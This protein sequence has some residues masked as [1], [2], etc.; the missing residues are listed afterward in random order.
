MY[1]NRERQKWICLL[2]PHKLDATILISDWEFN[3]SS[4][5]NIYVCLQ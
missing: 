2:S 5:F 4:D 1:V 3:T